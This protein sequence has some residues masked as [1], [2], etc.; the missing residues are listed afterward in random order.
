MS[1]FVASRFVSLS[2]VLVKKCAK[3]GL[4]L[5]IFVLFSAQWQ[6]QYK[7]DYK[8]RRWCA[9]DSNPGRQAQTNPLS[10]GGTP[11]LAL[12]S[13]RKYFVSTVKI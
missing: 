3:P 12:V 8:K 13:A 10:Y 11:S 2:L 7:F 1:Y 6:I 5:F 9:W 4:F